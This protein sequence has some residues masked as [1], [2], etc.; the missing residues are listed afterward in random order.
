MTGLLP[1][2][3]ENRELDI[4]GESGTSKAVGFRL[5]PEEYAEIYSSDDESLYD[6]RPIMFLCCMIVY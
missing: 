3:M 6:V 4:H 2:K 5:L 1:S